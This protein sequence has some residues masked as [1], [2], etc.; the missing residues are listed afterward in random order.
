MSSSAS[1][2]NGWAECFSNKYQQ[3]YWFN[4][5][6]NESKWVNPN[7]TSTSATN[8]VSTNINTSQTS[9]IY[10]DSPIVANQRDRYAEECLNVLTNE[11]LKYGEMQGSTKTAKSCR[12][13]GMKIG[14]YGIYARVIWS[15]LLNQVVTVGDVGSNVRDSIFPTSILHDA[16]VEKEFLDGGRTLAQAQDILSKLGNSLVTASRN[17]VRL[18]TEQR[19]NLDSIRITL[20]VESS[21]HNN[22]NNKRKLTTDNS[23]IPVITTINKNEVYCLSFEEVTHSIS[24]MHFA[25]LLTLYRLHTQGDATVNDPVFVSFIFVCCVCVLCVGISIHIHFSITTHCGSCCAVHLVSI[26]Y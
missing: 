22:T 4:A 13:D 6:T 25:K 9:K 18:Q 1:E 23:N 12:K 10:E 15:Q 19:D 24:G 21:Q 14:M 11:N 2:V 3:K 26:P 16:A 20:T 8:S 5:S 17:L 7:E